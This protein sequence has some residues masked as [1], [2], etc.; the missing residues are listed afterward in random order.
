MK[1]T[2]IYAA[3]LTSSLISAGTALAANGFVTSKEQDS[4]KPGMTAAQ[5]TDVAGKPLRVET[6]GANKDK[7]WVYNGANASKFVVE[8]SSDGKVVRSQ[9][10][11]KPNGS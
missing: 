4:I 10:Q 9:A 7:A 11:N 5:V 1:K 2:L 3:I 6:Y 8:F